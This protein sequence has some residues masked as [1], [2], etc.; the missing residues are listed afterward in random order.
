MCSINKL[1]DS[2]ILPIFLP[3]FSAVLP[4]LSLGSSFVVVIVDVV[5]IYLL[6][7]FTMFCLHVCLHTRRGHQISLW[8]VVSHRVVPGN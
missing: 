7:M 5:K 6:I 1:S 4:E 2:L 3:L 8:M